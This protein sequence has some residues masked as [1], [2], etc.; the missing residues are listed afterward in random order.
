ME[1]KAQNYQHDN[2]D[3][4]NT[5][6]GRGRGRTRSTEQGGDATQNAAEH[7]ARGVEQR[8]EERPQVG[9]K[10]FLPQSIRDSSNRRR[11]HIQVRNTREGLRPMAPVPLV[12]ARG[13]N[14][15]GTMSKCN[16]R[17]FDVYLNIFSHMS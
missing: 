1:T 16:L 11:I 17:I 5:E 8:R 4:P 14:L 13:G 2:G 6:G 10:R 3:A 15:M 12:D 9:K 7:G